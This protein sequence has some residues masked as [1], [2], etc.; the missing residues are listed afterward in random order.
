MTTPSID[1]RARQPPVDVARTA[2]RLPQELERE[3]FQLAA[4]SNQGC[5]G[6]LMRVARRT[7]TWTEPFLFVSINMYASGADDIQQTFFLEGRE[8]PPDFFANAVRHVVVE[9]WGP[10]FC[11]ALKLCTKAT[12]VA[13]AGIPEDN[14]DEVFAIFSQMPL[15]RLATHLLDFLHPTGD[16]HKHAELPFAENL[17]HL[18]LFDEDEINLEQLYPF[19]TSLPSLTH[20]ALA[21]PPS[22]TFIERLLSECSKLQALVVLWEPTSADEGY[23]AAQAVPLRDARFA[24]CTFHS[25]EEGVQH[26]YSEC[27][28]C[29]WDSV[30]RLIKDKRIR[31]PAHY[32]WAAWSWPPMQSIV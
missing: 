4:S 24:M 27:A 29:Y 28:R 16:I 6:N 11:A 3:I 1:S 21:F 9:D 22:W 5:I 18:D 30:E 10:I 12:H 23:R 2:P 14:Q 8:R 26:P 31:T 15:R 20:L 7:L 17:T 32:F 13:I 25:W 19:I